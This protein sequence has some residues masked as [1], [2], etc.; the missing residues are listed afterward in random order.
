MVKQEY[1]SLCV[2]IPVVP[3][4]NH[5]TLNIVVGKKDSAENSDTWTDIAK[6]DRVCQEIV[7]SPME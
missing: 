1:F 7:M 5:V 3:L 6:N 2:L 4:R